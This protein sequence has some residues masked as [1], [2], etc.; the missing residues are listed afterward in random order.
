MFKPNFKF[1]LNVK[2]SLQIQSVVQSSG[3]NK[4]HLLTFTKALKALAEGMK[5]SALMNITLHGLIKYITLY[6][7]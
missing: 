5:N 2:K 6:V 1:C 4:A 3:K 7:Y